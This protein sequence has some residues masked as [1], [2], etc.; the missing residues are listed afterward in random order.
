MVKINRKNLTMI[1]ITIAFTA[2]L[3]ALSAHYSTKAAITGQEKII[4]IMNTRIGRYNINY[5]GNTNHYTRY[6]PNGD[7]EHKRIYNDIGGNYANSSTS[8]LL[9][10]TDTSRIK[11]A[12]LIWE[13]RAKQSASEP[14]TLIKP[15][16]KTELIYP[17]Y[18]INDY[19]IVGNNTPITTLFCMATDVT[20]IVTKSGYGKY[21]VGNIPYFNY[22]DYGDTGGGE[23]PG[24]WQLIV[25]EE[26]DNFPIRAVKLDMGAKFYLAKDFNS[27][28]ILDKGLKSTSVGETTAQIFFG[29]SSAS[30][31][32]PMTENISTYDNRS[33]IKNIVSNTTESPGLYRNGNMVNDR[34]KW[35]GC[36]R[37][38][39][40]DVRNVG[41]NA[42]RIELNVNN[43]DWTTPFLLGLAVDI[44]YPDFQGIQNTIVNNSK[45][46]RIEGEFT[47]IAQ[48]RNTGIYNGNMTVD[49][50]KALTPI[51]A[52]AVVDDK[53]EIQ[54]SINGNTVTFSGDSV[55]SMMNGSKITYNIQCSINSNVD[56]FENS[57]SFQGYL[58]SDGVNTGYWIDR[59]W[60]A[61]SVASP[62]YS[63]TVTGDDGIENVT[64]GG[65]YNYGDKVNIGAIVK[66]GYIFENWT[67]TE[68]FPDKDFTITV[69]KDL[70]ITANTRP[71]QYTIVYDKN[72]TVYNSYGDKYTD[73][74]KYAS[75]STSD[76][77]CNY[78]SDVTI[79]TN[80]F[81]RTGYTFKHWN[82]KPDGSGTTYTQGQILNKAN[83]TTVD[84]AQ[85][86]LYAIWEPNKYNIK[87]NSN[88]DSLGNWN[89]TDSYTHGIIRVDQI[90]SLIPNTFTRNTPIRLSNGVDLSGGYNYIG[91]G[92]TGVETTPVWND[93]QSIVNLSYK[94]NDVVNLIALW[95]KGITL[96][97]SPKYSGATID[98][99]S[100]SVVMKAKIYN[101]DYTY[102][103]DITRYY[104]QYDTNGLNSS[105]KYTDAEGIKYRFLGYNHDKTLKVPNEVPESNL[106]VYSSNRDNIYT[107]YDTDN[108]YAMWEPVLGLTS[109]FGRTLDVNPNTASA[110]ALTSGS[111]GTVMAETSDRM[112]YNFT[113]TGYADEVNV[114]VDSLLTEV[115]REARGNDQYAKYNDNLNDAYIDSSMNLNKHHTFT[116]GTLIHNIGDAFYIP[117]YTL[118]YQEQKYG[119]TKYRDYYIKITAINNHSYYW[120]KYKN[121]P[122]TAIITGSIHIDSIGDSGTGQEHDRL[123][124]SLRY[125]D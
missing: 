18:A 52:V 26:D 62:K 72:D 39:L 98:N 83:I 124:Y 4:T 99:S 102:D 37:M 65:E 77:V 123:K 33:L 1:V 3:V 10:T 7:I 85:I 114:E 2:M 89:T 36:I 120:T 113:K 76:T 20:Q 93:K 56:K 42:N 121:T 79:S 107:I 9:K 49:V 73:N 8:T 108:L 80:G 91:W 54:G 110:D 119:Y 15:D 116:M 97:L 47:N 109:V 106:D 100:S 32:I 61:S 111:L 24:S 48:T 94:N 30:H 96:N 45:N 25:I 63:I 58:R 17:E 71:I 64:G 60:R 125:G 14:V 43:T 105:N 95:E 115:Y 82:T 21:S 11:Y 92:K 34:D 122:E 57:A 51:K 86:R 69:D 75:G 35:M 40:T 70:N 38:D 117:Q 12:Y 27:E 31:F 6:Y 29:A 81:N 88:D 50:D 16:G 87:Y 53:T 46:A 23:S 74:T 103:F 5:T 78:D 112:E 13:S 67:G 66:P 41:N 19:R 90:V 22:G 55:A 59:M 28:L 68:Q 104:G 101:H 84:G 118:G 44:A